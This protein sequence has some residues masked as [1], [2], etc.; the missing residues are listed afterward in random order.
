MRRPFATA[1]PRF[2]V[3]RPPPCYNA[4]MVRRRFQFDLSQLFGFTALV[5]VSI[6]SY[7]ASARL[8]AIRPQPTP[9]YTFFVVLLAFV[10]CGAAGAAVGVFF[11]RTTECATIACLVFSLVGSIIV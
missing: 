3:G 1:M 9:S 11:R 5:S 4:T 2:P 10:S 6:A 8:A 7:I